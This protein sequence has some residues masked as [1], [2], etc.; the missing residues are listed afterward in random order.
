MTVSEKDV[1]K[2]I[3][4]ELTV[5]SNYLKR[6]GLKITNQ[7]LLVAE[8]IFRE[9]SHFTVDSLAD[10][11]KDRKGEISRATI[12]R[13]VSLL[14][15]S[16][17]LSEH[18]FGENM[19]YYEHTHSRAHHDH[20]VCLDCKRIDEFLA[21]NIEKLQEQIAGQHDYTLSEHSLILYCHCRILEEKGSC[22]RKNPESNDNNK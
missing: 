5:F 15:D 2:N 21:P 13:I 9:T 18:D 14:V 16:G 10:S 12:Y 20:I 4:G 7:R 8:K 22:P 11:L 3:H 19:N 6:K 1:I 17:Q